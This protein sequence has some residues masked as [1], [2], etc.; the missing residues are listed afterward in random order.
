M[1]QR[2]VVIVTIESVSAPWSS[3][4]F[5]SILTQ[6]VVPGLTL[7]SEIHGKNLSFEN[8]EITRYL[9]ALE[10]PIMNLWQEDGKARPSKNRSTRLR[11]KKTPEPHVHYRDWRSS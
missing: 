9:S 1:V 7:I 3:Q 6:A 2:P 4:D 11:P 8:E 10:L 5:S